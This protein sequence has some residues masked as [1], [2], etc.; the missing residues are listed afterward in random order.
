MSNGVQIRTQ[1]VSPRINCKYK[2]RLSVNI[3]TD[4]GNTVRR[5]PNRF[6]MS[7]PKTTANEIGPNRRTISFLSFQRR[8]SPNAVIT[9]CSNGNALR[10]PMVRQRFQQFGENNM[11]KS[12]SKRQDSELKIQQFETLKSHEKVIFLKNIHAV[13]S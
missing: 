3:E 9:K 12:K 4:P 5:L 13:I 7:K 1:F 6:L 11:L 2:T 10:S 8:A